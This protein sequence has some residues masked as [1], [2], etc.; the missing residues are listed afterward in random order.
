M[1]LSLQLINVAVTQ[2]E[3]WKAFEAITTLKS[4][5]EAVADVKRDGQ[6]PNAFLDTD[7]RFWSVTCG[8]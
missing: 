3:N 6:G 2:H 5:M 7:K 1:L 8:S 4:S